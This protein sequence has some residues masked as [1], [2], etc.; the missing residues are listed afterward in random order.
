MSDNLGLRGVL[1]SLETFEALR[2]TGQK[3]PLDKVRRLI[4][5]VINSLSV[6]SLDW[7]RRESPPG[8]MAILTKAAGVPVDRYASESVELLRDIDARW[9][10]MREARDSLAALGPKVTRSVQIENTP[11]MD[12]YT[13]EVSF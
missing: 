3:T 12:I 6:P 11:D 5:T 13:V 2:G 7:N 4:I 10:V 8:T 9:T 1:D